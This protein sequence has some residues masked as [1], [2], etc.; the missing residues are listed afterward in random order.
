M[1]QETS[2]YTFESKTIDELQELGKLSGSEKTIISTNNDTK[3][4]SIDTIVGYAA[5]LIAQQMGGQS[6]ST[7]S[8][9]VTNHSNAKCIVVIPEGESIPISQ[10]TPGTIYFEKEKQTSIRTKINVPTSIVV[11][12]TLGLRR[13]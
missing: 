2:S 8:L 13:I 3:K 6:V 5:N 12:G 4:V 1:A 7:T 11:S 9:I 10:R